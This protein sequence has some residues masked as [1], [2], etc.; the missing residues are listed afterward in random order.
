M[1]VSGAMAGLAFAGAASADDVRL[2]DGTKLRATVADRDP[3]YVLLRVSRDQVATV[4]GKPLASPPEEGQA[5]P[6]FEM[7]DLSRNRQAIPDPVGR[8]TLLKFWASWCP[9]CRGD[10]ALMKDLQ[11]KYGDKGLRILAVSTDQDLE[12]L[13][14]FV[15]EQQLPYPVVAGGLPGAKEGE[16]LPERYEVSGIPVYFVVDANGRIM[17]II[18][19]AA[20]SKGDELEHAL[21]AALQVTRRKTR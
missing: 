21:T 13:K 6:P 17:K 19:G 18:H 4:N 7:A 15:A 11:A 5:A 3:K 8:A 1:A 20:K 10:I 14:S 16:A 9:Y 2:K 12:K